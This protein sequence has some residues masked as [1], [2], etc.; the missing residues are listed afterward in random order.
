[1]D[2]GLAVSFHQ[3]GSVL[4]YIS[5]FFSILSAGDYFVGFVKVLRDK[6]A[7]APPPPPPK[8]TPPRPVP[9]GRAGATGAPS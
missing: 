8:A 6:P 1:M 5:V 7:E 9:K 2:A 4:L 3:I